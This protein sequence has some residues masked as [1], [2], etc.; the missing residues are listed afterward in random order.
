MKTLF[1]T[2]FIALFTSLNAVS[3]ESDFNLL[4]K[5]NISNDGVVNYKSIINQKEKLVSY[6]QY[7]EKTSPAK[8]WSPNKTKAFWI[9]AYN[10]YTILTIVNNY[11]VKS[12]LDIKTDGKD[13][14]HIPNALVGGKKYTLNDIEHIQLREKFN[15]PRI[16]VGVNCASFSCPPIANFAFTEANVEAELERLMK[17]FVNDPKRNSLTAKKVSLSK[18][19]EWYKS[20]F[21]QK[22]SLIDYLNSYSKITLS[23]KTKIA[24]LEYNW[25]LNE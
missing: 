22:G 4:L 11:P 2:L 23:K 18:I 14:W 16:H 12:I 9:N 5:E 10:A 3:Q 24:Y 1:I 15:D 6:I 21:T 17:K 20:D 7:L 19:F 13:A 8:N 25:S